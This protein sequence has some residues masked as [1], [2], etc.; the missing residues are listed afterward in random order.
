MKI[1]I[2]DGHTI[3][4]GDNSWAPVEALGECAIYDRTPPELVLERAQD[5]EIILVSKVKLSEAIIARC[6]SVL[7]PWRSCLGRPMLSPSTVPRQPKTPALSI[8]ASLP[9]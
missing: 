2:L 4:P 1:V 8:P 6:R 9:G 7:S 3:N 5:A